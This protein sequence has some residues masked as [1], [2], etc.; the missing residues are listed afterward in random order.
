MRRRPRRRRETLRFWVFPGIGGQARLVGAAIGEEL[1]FAPARFLGHL[2]QET[3]GE[4]TLFYVYAIDA[5]TK[6]KWVGGF[7][8]WGQDGYFDIEV[9]QVV[10]GDWIVEKAGVG[11]S[12]G[13]S[14]FDDHIYEWFVGGELADAAAKLVAC[15][16]GN[17]A[18]EVSGKVRVVGV[19]R[20]S[21]P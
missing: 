2:W 9:G 3:A 8:Q 15:F 12:G 5:E 16:E 18:A 19:A 1:L 7:F 13:L 17:E 10:E 14:H 11:C 6:G 21:S 4:V 20:A